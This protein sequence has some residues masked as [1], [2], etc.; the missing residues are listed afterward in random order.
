M[1]IRIYPENPNPREIDK[2]VQFLR[3]G[4]LIVYPTDTIYGLGCD[5]FHTK[6]VEKICR[7]KGIDVRKAN[8]SFICYDLSHISEY[9]KVSNDTF[10]L[11][12]KNLPGPFTFILN[13]NNNLPKLFRNKKTVG[14]RIPDNNIIREL[15]KGL[16]NPILSTS[17]HDADDEIQEYFT[18]PELIHERYENIADVVINAG[19]GSLEPSTVVDCTGD[20]PVVVRQGKGELIF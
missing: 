1:L 7:Y 9:A 3:D 11:M 4:G 2:V 19:Y 12:K 15:V 14:I 8:L 6:A 18:D 5:I 13:G 17:V 20:E 16:G 10:K